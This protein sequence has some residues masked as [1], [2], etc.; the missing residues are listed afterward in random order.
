ML[1]QFWHT[2]ACYVAFV[3]WV[4]TGLFQIDAS[5]KAELHMA[6]GA[7]PYKLKTLKAL[8]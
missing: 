5:L 8:L 2:C 3:A 6:P 1:W 7:Q 4:Y